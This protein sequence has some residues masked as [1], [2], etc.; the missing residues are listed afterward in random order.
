MGTLAT[1]VVLYD[2]CINNEETY[3]KFDSEEFLDSKRQ[4]INFLIKYVL[5]TS[6]LLLLPD[7]GELVTIK[8]LRDR[9]CLYNSVSMI[10]TG[11]N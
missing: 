8:C 2:F 9:K 10:L 3:A 4:L 7:A 1:I 11:D 5:E 6:Q